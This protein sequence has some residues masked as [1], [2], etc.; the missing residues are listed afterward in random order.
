MFVASKVD[1]ED[2][3]RFVPITC[4]FPLVCRCE[5]Q[6]LNKLTWNWIHHIENYI[7]LSYR[8]RCNLKCYDEPFTSLECVLIL[9]IIDS[10]FPGCSCQNFAYVFQMV[11]WLEMYEFWQQLHIFLFFSHWSHH[12]NR[13]VIISMTFLSLAALWVVNMTIFFTA[14]DD[15]FISMLTFLFQ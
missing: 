8:N 3:N 5:C 10:L 1:D 13:N 15:D 9:W 4:W 7:Y 14:I 12:W 11:S 6:G 2:I